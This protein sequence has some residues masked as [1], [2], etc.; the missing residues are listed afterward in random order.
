AQVHP[1]PQFNPKLAGAWRFAWTTAKEK[2][3]ERDAVLV[4]N[5]SSRR[6][7][8]QLHIHIVRLAPG[9]RDAILKLAPMQRRTIK[10]LGEAWAAAQQAAK[11]SEISDYGVAVMRDTGTGRFIVAVV[12][13]SPEKDFS[14]YSCPD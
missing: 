7:Q 6:T 14:V 4:M 12:A 8:D 5:P 11:A 2:I 10:N 1:G 13:D 9:A 3:G